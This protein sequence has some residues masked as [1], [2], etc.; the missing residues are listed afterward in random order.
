MKNNYLIQAWL[1]LMLAICFGSA[2]AGMEVALKDKI[3]ANKLNETLDQI[4]NLVPGASAEHSK[5]TEVGGQTVFAAKDTGGKLIGWVVSASGQGFADAIEVLIGLNNDATKI[6]GVYVL[7]QKE[8]PGLGDNI[9]KN[10]WTDQFAKRDTRPALV[11]TKASP[12][13]PNDIWSVSGATI[14]SDSVTKIVNDA[15]AKL[16]QPLKAAATQ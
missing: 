4:P 6:T 13:A 5:Q 11:V 14:S 3:Q 15:V 9:T 7:S 16:A 8:T 10:G 2:L 1:V 12:M